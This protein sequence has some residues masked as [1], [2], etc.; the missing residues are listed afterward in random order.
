MSFEGSR[1]SCSSKPLASTK[2]KTDGIKSVV[3]L[4]FRPKTA[5]IREA[6]NS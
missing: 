5:L 1:Y 3:A 6:R 4:H 2:S